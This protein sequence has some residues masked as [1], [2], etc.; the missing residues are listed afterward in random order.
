[1]DIGLRVLFV[2][3]VIVV[4]SLGAGFVGAWWEQRKRKKNRKG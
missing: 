1:M 3:L 4:G 2:L